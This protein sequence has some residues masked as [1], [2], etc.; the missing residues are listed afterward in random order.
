MRNAILCFVPVLTL[1]FAS[2]QLKAESSST[3]P[4]PEL[5]KEA[6]NIVKIFS[7]TLKPKLKEAIQSGGIEHAIKVCSVEAPKIA[8]DLS[9]QTGW[10][11]KRV[12]LKPRNTNNARPD[13][14][15]RN[16]LTK[17]DL[18]QAKSDS[19]TLLQYSEIVNNKYRYMK[20][21]AV[22]GICLNCHGSSISADAKK[23]L[24]QYYPEDLA[25]GYTLGDIR[26]AFSLVKEL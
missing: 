23:T 11:I 2:S 5:R 18:H 16:I 15:E 25:T 21:Q 10:S 17:F 1:C 26:G 24:N 13:T 19:S 6:M 20:A 9:A 4:E 14:F 8:Y 3:E 12:S 22:E 7:D